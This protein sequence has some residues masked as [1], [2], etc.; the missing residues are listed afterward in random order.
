MKKHFG[1]FGIAHGGIFCQSLLLEQQAEQNIHTHGQGCHHQNRNAY[2]AVKVHQAAHNRRNRNR[3][4]A[5]PVHRRNIFQ[6]DNAL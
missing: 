6:G 5:T 2:E 1:K 3:D 4:N